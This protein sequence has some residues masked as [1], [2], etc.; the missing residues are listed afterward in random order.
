MND[1]FN[2]LPLQI[3]QQ[4]RSTEN[5]YIHSLQTVVSVSL[6]GSEKRTHKT[7]EVY[8]SRWGADS[9]QKISPSESLT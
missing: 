8:S 2:E 6:H 7:P 3:G 9:K 5:D 1:R 4:I